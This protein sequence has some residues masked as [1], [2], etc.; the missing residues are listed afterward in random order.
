MNIGHPWTQKEEQILRETLH[1]GGSY[2]DV[3]EKTKHSERGVRHKA[4]RMGLIARTPRRKRAERLIPEY[5][6]T[7]GDKVRVRKGARMESTGSVR[8]GIH[9]YTY[10]ETL[11]SR[12]RKHV[13]RHSVGYVET[14]TD[15]QLFESLV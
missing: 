13:F 12:V 15:A 6:F 11:G 5:N 8:G 10:R 14:F 9:E 3:S 1:A 4:N 7:P 2:E